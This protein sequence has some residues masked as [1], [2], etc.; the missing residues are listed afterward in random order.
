VP[1]RH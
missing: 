1:Y